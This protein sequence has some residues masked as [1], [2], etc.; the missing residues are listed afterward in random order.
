MYQNL[1]I[2]VLREIFLVSLY[3]TVLLLFSKLG[4]SNAFGSYLIHV[5][6][7]QLNSGKASS[8]HF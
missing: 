1:P 2:S 8:A 5:T 6:V 3:L 7:I 4:K